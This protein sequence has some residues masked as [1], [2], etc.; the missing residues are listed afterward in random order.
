MIARK[1]NKWGQR[2]GS[3]RFLDVSDKKKLEYQLDHI[4]IREKKLQAN[5]PRFKRGEK[6][7]DSVE[8]NVRKYDAGEGASITEAGVKNRKWK[9]YAQ[10]VMNGGG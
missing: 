1:N 9:M 7:Q 6:K 5:L 2:F 8:M 4:Q 3:M 10:A